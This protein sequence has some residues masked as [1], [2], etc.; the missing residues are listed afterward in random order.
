MTDNPR[1]ALYGSLYTVYAANKMNYK[2]DFKTTIG[3]R[4][5][6]S[7]DILQENVILPTPQPG[8]I[9]AFAVTGAYN[10][11]MAS[12]YNRIPRPPIVMINGKTDRIVV[13]RETF[14]DLVNL[15][16]N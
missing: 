5:C 12:N 1:F 10:Y 11:A 7:G 8:D 16:V 15:D 4:C 14:E 3:G 9:I 13:R 2:A 6:E